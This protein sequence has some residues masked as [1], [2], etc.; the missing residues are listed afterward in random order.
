MIGLVQLLGKNPAGHRDGHVGRLLP[1][2]SE[3][4]VASLGDVARCALLAIT[5]CTQQ[6]RRGACNRRAILIL[7]PGRGRAAW[8][9]MTYSPRC[10]NRQLQSGRQGAARPKARLRGAHPFRQPTRVGAATVR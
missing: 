2:L 10:R 8:G 6:R 7:P 1:D 3:C 5:G 9:E 4:L